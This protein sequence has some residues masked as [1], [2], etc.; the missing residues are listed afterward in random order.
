ML[1]R[2]TIV[3]GD[4]RIDG[5]VGDGGMGVVYE[6]TQ[7]SLDRTVALKLVSTAFSQDAGFRERFRRE[8]RLQATLEHAHVIDVY[9]AGQS[10]QGL[11]LAMRLVRGP[12]LAALIGKPALTVE[13]TQRLLTQIASALDAAHDVGL[14][15]R[16]LKPHNILIDERRDHSYLADF[17][18]TKARGTA[19]L[20]QVGQLVGTL[21]YMAPEQFRG[22]EA[23]ERSD[24]YSFGAV[25]FES[26]VGTVPYAMPTEA[27]I[28]NAHLS[29]AVPKITDHRPELPSGVDD[30][31]ARAMAKEPEERYATATALMEELAATLAAEAPASRTLISDVPETPPPVD[32]TRIVPAPEP[33]PD[34]PETHV[35]SDA[36]APPTAVTPA[37]ATELLTTETTAPPVEATTISKQEEVPQEEV[38]P[39][40]V[41]PRPGRPAGR[42]K[43]IWAVGAAAI[44]GLAVA[45]FVG[46]SHSAPD[47][48]T[49]VVDKSQRNVKSGA[50]AVAVPVSWKRA[51]APSIPGLRLGNGLSVA[52]SGAGGLTAGTVGRAWPTFLPAPFRKAIGAAAVTR[53]Q[54]VKIGGLSAYRYANVKPKGY[55]GSMTVYA[56]PQAKSEWIAAC[57]GASGAPPKECEDVAASLSVDGAK[58]YDLA[59]SAAY[60]AKIRGAVSALDGARKRGLAAL[61]KGSSQKAQSTSARQVASAYATFA[62]RLAAAGPPAYASPVHAR[63][64]SAAGSTQRAY[65]ALA[66]AAAA[67]SQGRYDAAR[68]LVRKREAQLR[69]ALAGLAQLGYQV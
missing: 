8:G 24:I 35:T 54:L 36:P 51:S 9:A 37:P 57:W 67:G 26:I 30:V 68:A 38:A 60:A 65:A 18:V 17:G 32:A 66:G 13:R 61:S 52:P 2:G 59:P 47:K 42:S 33:P 69:T 12:S 23:T 46:G 3:A 28:I 56:V 1:E 44:L 15:H 11:Y 58:D 25:L 4:F 16:D 43:W 40:P 45:G 27:S 6:A 29:E 50:L 34:T 48:Q 64:V 49:T 10:D 63:I 20:T 19:G 5:V 62:R 7:L 31:I 21:A 22:Y 14:I 55:A 41:P 39:P 53:G